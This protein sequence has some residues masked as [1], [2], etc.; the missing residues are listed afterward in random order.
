MTHPV[1]T[2]KALLEGWALGMWLRYSGTVI[3]RR[4]NPCAGLLGQLY[5]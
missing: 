2:K 3:S 1:F 4:L 5:D